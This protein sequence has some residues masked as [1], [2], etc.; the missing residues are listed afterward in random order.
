MKSYSFKMY[1][2]IIYLL[3]FTLSLVI[4]V[5]CKEHIVM[6]CYMRDIASVLI[7]ISKSTFFNM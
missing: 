2:Y 5:K 3:I 6:L 4:H 1:I 7:F